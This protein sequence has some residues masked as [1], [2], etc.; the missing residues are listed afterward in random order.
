MFGLMQLI[1]TISVKLGDKMQSVINIGR[2]NWQADS[3][4]IYGKDLKNVKNQLID[5][6]E[7]NQP[8]EKRVWN[9][10]DESIQEIY[11]ECENNILE[12]IK[13]TELDFVNK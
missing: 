9:F 7:S 10:Y 6:I 11:K 3:Y 12:K 2:L 13:Q 5:K 4:H 1:K 8:F